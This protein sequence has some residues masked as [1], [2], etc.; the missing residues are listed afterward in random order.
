MNR[1]W[2]EVSRDQNGM[3][4]VDLLLPK[5]RLGGLE[6]LAVIMEVY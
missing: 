2:A 4:L 1:Y 6:A 5:K 3:F